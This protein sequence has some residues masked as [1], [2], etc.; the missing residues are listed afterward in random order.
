MRRTHKKY[1]QFRYLNFTNH[2]SDPGELCH[3]TIGSWLIKLFND[4]GVSLWLYL[5]ALVYIVASVTSSKLETLLL[6]S[7]IIQQN[8]VINITFPW[9]LWNGQEIKSL[10]N[11]WS[12]KSLEPNDSAFQIWLSTNIYSLINAVTRHGLSFQSV[13]WRIWYWWGYI[14]GRLY[15]QFWLTIS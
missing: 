8:S 1:I 11:D 6:H 9:W 3:V 15:R 4:L 13:K 7:F 12:V 10:Q 5:L 14:V 2:L